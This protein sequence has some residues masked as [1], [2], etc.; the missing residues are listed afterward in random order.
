MLSNTDRNDFSMS[1]SKQIKTVKTSP[2]G[3]QQTDPIGPPGPQETDLISSAKPQHIDAI[4]P[5]VYLYIAGEKYKKW[6]EKWG[7][8]PRLL[9]AK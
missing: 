8:S 6:L 7:L 4:L 5:P 9:N 2:P 1:Y 3:P